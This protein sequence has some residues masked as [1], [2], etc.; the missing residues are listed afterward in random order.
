M[1]RRAVEKKLTKLLKSDYNPR[2][3][4][5][6]I[7]NSYFSKFTRNSKFRFRFQLADIRQ[8]LFAE[9]KM[10]LNQAPILSV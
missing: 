1:R 8:R 9:R 10:D 2:F 3:S 6:F 5:K 4:S 7:Q